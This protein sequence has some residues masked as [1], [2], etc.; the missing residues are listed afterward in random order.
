MNGAA[1]RLDRT[2]GQVEDQGGLTGSLGLPGYY[3]FLRVSGSFRVVVTPPAGYQ[4]APGQNASVDV[5]FER[6][7]QMTLNF[8]LRRV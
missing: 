5:R 4:L 1:V 6:N 2:N 3:F 7:Q 8:V